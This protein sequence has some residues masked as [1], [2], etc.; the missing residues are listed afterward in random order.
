MKQ[1]HREL[2]WTLEALLPAS[3]EEKPPSPT[4]SP[5]KDAVPG[6]GGSQGGS[7]AVLTVD[8]CQG[9]LAQACPLEPSKCSAHSF[10]EL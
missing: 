1:T 2:L 10:V 3:E 5:N 8:I 7:S 6:C 9:N 4:S